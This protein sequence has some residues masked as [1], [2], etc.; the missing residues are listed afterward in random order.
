MDTVTSKW[1]SK[2][3]FYQGAVFRSWPYCRRLPCYRRL[4]TSRDSCRIWY[5]VIRYGSLGAAVETSVIYG[6]ML[7]GKINVSL[8]KK[9]KKNAGIFQSISK[10][11]V[12]LLYRWAAQVTLFC[13]PLRYITNHIF[14]SVIW[15][16]RSTSTHTDQCIHLAIS[17]FF[18][19]LFLFSPFSLSNPH[20]LIPIF[21]RHTPSPRHIIP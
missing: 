19:L 10:R 17:F 6:R 2:T 14:H 12:W 4:L 16:W 5:V 13:T 20:P 21:D 7:E 9:E 15:K 18:S 1:T 11:I 3:L 8:N